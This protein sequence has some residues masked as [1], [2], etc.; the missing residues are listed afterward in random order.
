MSSLLLEELRLRSLEGV[1]KRAED[2]RERAEAA[3]KEEK[4][5]QEEFAHA[6]LAELP[7]KLRRSAD[8]GES[9]CNVYSSR[10]YRNAR[11]LDPV[12]PILEQWAKKQGLQ[13]ESHPDYDVGDDS[14]WT[15]FFLSGWYPE[16]S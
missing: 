3:R 1:L 2:Q 8:L 10:F 5:A 14:Q 9:R 16:Q 6:L 11:D 13:L 15:D 4:R 7:D 12:V